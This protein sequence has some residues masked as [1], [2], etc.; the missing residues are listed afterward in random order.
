MTKEEHSKVFSLIEE[1]LSKSMF[2][3]SEVHWGMSLKVANLKEELNPDK[4]EELDYLPTWS[5]Y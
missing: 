3:S 5:C 2:S 1:I 4:K